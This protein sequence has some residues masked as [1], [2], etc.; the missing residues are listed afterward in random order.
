MT[1]QDDLFFQKVDLLKVTTVGNQLFEDSRLSWEAAHFYMVAAYYVERGVEVTRKLMVESYKGGMG[2]RMYSRCVSELEE[3]GYLIRHRTRCSNGRFGRTAWEL[4]LPSMEHPSMSKSKFIEE[5]GTSGKPRWEPCAHFGHMDSEDMRDYEKVQVGARVPKCARGDVESTKVQVGARVPKCAHG[6][7]E[8][9]ITK[10]EQE[11]NPN[12]IE[13]SEALRENMVDSPGL[14]SFARAKKHVSD[15][16]GYILSNVDEETVAQ[17]FGQVLPK[18][19][20]LSHLS[21]QLQQCRP[22]VD[23]MYEPPRDDS[24]KDDAE[25]ERWRNIVSNAL[26]NIVSEGGR[27]KKLPVY[28]FKDYGGEVRQRALADWHCRTRMR[29]L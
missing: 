19:S 29:R 13:K 1:N 8:P 24:P 11:S 3:L 18:C 20:N 23:A 9:H 28:W 6:S 25:S 12:P 21:D 7:S 17:A 14:V 10:Q 27:Q 22:E 4:S 15:S 26:S 5:S 16:E 2:R